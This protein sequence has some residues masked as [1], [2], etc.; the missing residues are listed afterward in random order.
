M[1]SLNEKFNFCAYERPFMYCLYFICERK[2]YARTQVNHS[3]CRIRVPT[4]TKYLKHYFYEVTQSRIAILKSAD[5]KR[6]VKRGST[7]AL[8]SDLS[9]I[10]SIL[11]ANVNFTHVRK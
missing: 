2:F 6:E 10:A 5:L 1:L 8:T 9:C 4:K 11:F 3:V 7:F